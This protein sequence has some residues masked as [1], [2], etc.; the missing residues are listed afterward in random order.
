MVPLPQIFQDPPLPPHPPKPTSFLILSHQKPN[1]HLRDRNKIKQACL[2]A[3]KQINKKP[4]DSNKK[5]KRHKYRHIDIHIV[6]Q[7]NPH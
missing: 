5:H 1:R 6:T 4:K 3:R 7:R 2:N